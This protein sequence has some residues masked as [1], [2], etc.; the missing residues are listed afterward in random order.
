MN[1]LK[2]FFM[3]SLIG[4]MVFAGLLLAGN[5]QGTFNVNENGI[6]L[7]GYDVVSYFTLYEALKGSE[8][9]EATYQDVKF[10]FANDENKEKFLKNPE[11]FLPQ[12]GGYCAFAVGK[13]NAKVPSNPQTF[14]LYEG[15][16]YLFFNDDYEGKRMNTIIPWNNHEKEMKK[17]A[18]TNWEKL[19]E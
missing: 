7:D 19:K 12:Y 8:K 18:D 17:M 3:F 5:P 11:N 6:V 2:H 1:I 16:L 14:K 9:F 15:K 4:F 10:W 13:K